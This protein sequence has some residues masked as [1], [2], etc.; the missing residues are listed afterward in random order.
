MTA[1]HDLDRPLTDL[2]RMADGAP[3]RVLRRGA[4][5]H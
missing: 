4:R 3:I 1:H 5:S 2:L